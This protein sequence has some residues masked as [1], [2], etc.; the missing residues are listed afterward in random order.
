MFWFLKWRAENW[1]LDRMWDSDFCVGI[2]SMKNNIDLSF[3]GIDWN[4]CSMTWW[5][6]L[7][8]PVRRKE[9]RGVVEDAQVVGVG[10]D[11]IPGDDF[12]RSK[13]LECFLGDIRFTR[14]L[15]FVS[16]FSSRSYPSIRKCTDYC[17]IYVSTNMA[18]KTRTVLLLR[19]IYAN[20]VHRQS[21]VS[22]VHLA[23]FQPGLG[24]MK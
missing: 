3:C 2:M 9:S 1:F 13:L 6:T 8:Y 24:R 18:L 10:S 12:L 21:H 20:H 11:P 23:V 7:C 16:S 5:V 22:V 19:P 4:H 14:F 15:R 17:R